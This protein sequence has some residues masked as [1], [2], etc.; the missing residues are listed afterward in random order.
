MS[1]EKELQ[2]NKKLKKYFEE[3][4]ISKAKVREALDSAK[5]L[6]AKEWYYLLDKLDLVDKRE[7]KKNG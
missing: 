2:T 3:A 6:T 4:Y 5:F 7:A 1:F